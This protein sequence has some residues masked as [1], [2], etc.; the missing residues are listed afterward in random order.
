MTGFESS[1]REGARNRPALLWEVQLGARRLV[2]AC[3][4][5]LQVRA[6]AKRSALAPEHCHSGR[7]VPVEGQKRLIQRLGMFRV[8]R[9]ARLRARMHHGEHPVAAFHTYQ[10]G[11]LAFNCVR[12]RE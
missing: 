12:K 11:S 2:V 1:R 3:R 8:Y 7:I 9:I 5:A 6:C 10:H 4:H